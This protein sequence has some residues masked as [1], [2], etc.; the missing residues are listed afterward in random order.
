MSK[1]IIRFAV[2]SDTHY[3]E[4]H[5]ENRLRF[6][7]ALE[8]VYGYSENQEYKTLDALYVVGDFTN[9]G[10]PEEFEMFKA[11]CGRYVLPET[12]LVV[13]L[14]N[15]ELHY[16]S[17]VGAMEKFSN[18][19]GTD[20]DRHEI[21]KGYHFISLS[22]M[23]YGGKWH[24]SFDENKRAFLRDALASA[25][26]EGEGKKPIFVFQHPGVQGT[27]LGGIFGNSELTDILKEYPEIIDFSGHS[28]CAV[29]DPKEIDQKDFTAVSTG[30]LY[31]ICQRH[32]TVL[33]PY[34][35]RLMKPYNEYAQML[36]C[37][38]EADGG[39]RIK[40][41][42]VLGGDFFEDD[43]VIDNFGDKSAFIYTDERAKSAKAPY[44]EQNSRIS[45]DF[46][47][48]ALKISFPAAVG[49]SERV[50]EYHISLSDGAGEFY[51]TVMATD[52]PALVQEKEVNL[53]VDGIEKE[54]FS[55]SV[56]A[57]GFWENFSE[58]IRTEVDL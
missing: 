29:N 7:K 31:N 44:F 8:T 3:S 36:V 30:S 17:D 14:A 39:V 4:D 45:A 56:K 15:H 12:K 46:S 41:L 54:K 21:I 19:F 49:V 40:R 27:V 22:T 48:G 43:L 6:K 50:K 37:E 13:T 52:Y 34:I 11:D 5:P 18:L 53:T 47:D 35:D 28:H 58:E 55:I 24:D 16:H 1:V 25:H 10:L 26:K 38:V 57:A 2:M 23:Q 33:Y 20:F 51:K 42:D 9:K 32:K